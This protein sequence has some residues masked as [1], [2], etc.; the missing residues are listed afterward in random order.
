M[1][2]IECKSGYA[3]TQVSGNT[4]LFNRDQQG[5]F[6][7]LIEN[8]D[9]LHCL[10]SVS[11]YKLVDDDAPENMHNDTGQQAVAPK[12]QAGETKPRRKDK[13]G[14]GDSQPLRLPKEVE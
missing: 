11:H 3:E 6:V 13:A 4:Y 5:R 2:I 10:L 7:A 12:E 1:P 8:P 14:G 9:H